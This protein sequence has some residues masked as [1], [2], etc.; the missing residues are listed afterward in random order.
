MAHV[1]PGAAPASEDYRR[2]DPCGVRWPVVPLPLE[3]C[4]IGARSGSLRVVVFAKLWRCSALPTF[5]H[6]LVC[7]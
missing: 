5:L 1:A 4:E 6:G 3:R 2:D 7:R